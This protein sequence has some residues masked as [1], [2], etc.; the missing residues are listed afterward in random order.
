MIDFIQPQTYKIIHIVGKEDSYQALQQQFHVSVAQIQEWNRL[1]PMAPLKVGQSILIWKSTQ[2]T[3]HKIISGDSL[4]Q[5]AAQ[6]YTT[7]QQLQRLNPGID[8][9]RLRLGQVLQVG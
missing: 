9:S 1:N 2:T 7:V 8:P 4:S 6:H 5:I 3:L